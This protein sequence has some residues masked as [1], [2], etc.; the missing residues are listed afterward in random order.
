[1]NVPEDSTTAPLTVSTLKGATI[2]L[3]KLGLSW[4]TT[5]PRAKVCTDGTH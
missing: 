1:M 3:V 5:E 2:A 4:R